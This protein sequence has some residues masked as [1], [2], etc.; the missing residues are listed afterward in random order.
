MHTQRL[1]VFSLMLGVIL[2][3]I[4]LVSI[5]P[6]T[7]PTVHHEETAQEA[8]LTFQSD[9]DDLQPC[10]AYHQLRHFHT[11]APVTPQ[12]SST[13]DANAPTPTP[14]PPTH[15][16]RPAPSVDR[17]GFP[18]NYETDFK[19]LFIFDRPDRRWLR[20]I[21]GNDVAAQ[22]QPGQAFAYG[23][24]LIMITYNALMDADGQPVLDE[25]G[26]YIG[27]SLIG[28]HAQ[29]KEPGFG[30]AYGADRAGEW[31]FMG[32]HL[33]GSVWTAPE[34]TNNCAACHLNE[35]GADNDFVFRMNLFHEGELGLIAPP[36]GENEVSIYLYSFHDPVL[37]VNVGT[38][39]TWINNDEA[40][41]TV[42]AAARNEAGA[43]VRAE[44]P[45]FES[46][47]LLSVS[48]AAGD[49]FSFTFDQPGEYLYRCSIHENMIGTIIVTD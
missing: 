25:D 16:P 47:V 18:E 31:E 4:V 23:S 32:Y 10:G 39:V 6:E 43:V 9:V 29:R 34:N 44:D 12:P 40:T 21:C 13:P 41:H 22:H 48:I 19:L 15:T 28:M 3:G 5:S 35:A 7:T 27:A 8:V 45:L 36:A 24:V 20:V 17:V 30:E 37:E 33:D 2:S 42:V 14:A 1:Y 38:T 49:S 11:P 46:E 26:H